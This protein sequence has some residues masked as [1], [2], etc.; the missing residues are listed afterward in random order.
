MK[1]SYKSEINFSRHLEMM[2]MIFIVPFAITINV[3][4]GAHLCT[5]TMKFK[6]IYEFLRVSCSQIEIGEMAN[7]RMLKKSIS[8]AT[9]NDPYK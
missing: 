2:F 4:K 1:N 6:K 5:L 3:K 8:N 9:Q 7:R